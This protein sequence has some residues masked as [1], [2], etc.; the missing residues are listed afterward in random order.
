MREIAVLI[1]AA[2]VV[3]GLTSVFTKNGSSISWLSERAV[4]GSTKQPESV[5]VASK[6]ANETNKSRRKKLTKPQDIEVT[7]EIVSSSNLPELP[8]S[9]PRVSTPDGIRVGTTAADLVRLYGAPTLRTV[10]VD[11]SRKIERYI[12]NNR[13]KAVTTVALLVN[14]RTVQTHS[15]Q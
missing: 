9:E 15:E 4:S 6:S 11:N 14:G 13:E 12:Y 8:P 3:T 10:Q 5:A 7:W 1:V 2:V